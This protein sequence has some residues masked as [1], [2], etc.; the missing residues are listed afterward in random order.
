MSWLKAMVLGVLLGTS[1]IAVADKFPVSGKCHMIGSMAGTIQRI[2][3]KDNID[4]NTMLSRADI[5]TPNNLKPLMKSIINS[6]YNN[7]PL[8]VSPTQVYERYTIDCMGI[9]A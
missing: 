8:G 4:I 9:E 7:V 5:Y 1:S 2:R 3:M 6:V